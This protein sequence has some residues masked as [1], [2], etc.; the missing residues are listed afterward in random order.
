[1]SGLDISIALFELINVPSVT[2]LLDG[3]KVY[4]FNRPINS[5]Q[6]DVVI[7]IPEYNAGQF[8]TGYIDINIHV[9]NLELQGDQTSPDLAT[10]KLI[11]DAVLALVGT[12]SGYSLTARIPGIPVRDSDGQWY[13]NI[14][15]AFT[16]IDPELGIDASL[17]SLSSVSDGYGGYTSVP[18]TVWTG[19]VAQVD[20]AKGNQLSTDISRFDFNLRSD[21]ILPKEAMPQKYMHLVTVEGKYVIRGIV[22]DGYNWR[23]HTY[24]KDG[25]QGSETT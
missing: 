10:M 4:R 5:R 14:R 17:V 6:R 9:P 20:I 1:M 19:K 13:C 15:L 25:Y 7:S 2:S 12:Q 11:T 24:R 8:N 21:W 23:V 3:G 18:T 22:P 16:L